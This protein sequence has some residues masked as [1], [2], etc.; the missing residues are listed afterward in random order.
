MKTVDEAFPV[1]LFPRKTV[2][3]QD[4]DYIVI[5]EPVSW[6]HS[7]FDSLWE[8]KDGK[9]VESDRNHLGEPV[10]FAISYEGKVFRNKAII[11]SSDEMKDVVLN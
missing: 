9:P 3:F 11:G 5:T 8:I 2:T 10:C 1:D 4:K 7:G 6:F